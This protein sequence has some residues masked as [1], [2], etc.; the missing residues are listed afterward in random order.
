MIDCCVAI[1]VALSED[2]SSSSN[3]AVPETA[4][5]NTGDVRVLFVSVCEPV[6]VATVLSIA[7]VIVLPLPVVSI[8]VPPVNVN[9]SESKSIDKAPPESP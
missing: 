5:L 1:F 9:A 8:P 4:V 3:I 2:K 7:K 6:S